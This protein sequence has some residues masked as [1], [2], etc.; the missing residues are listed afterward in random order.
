MMPNGDPR[1][2]FLY[3]TLTVMIDSYIILTNSTDY[4]IGI[5]TMLFWRCVPI[6]KKKT[7]GQL[8]SEQS[9]ASYRAKVLYLLHS[10][11][12]LTVYNFPESNNVSIA[13]IKLRYTAAVG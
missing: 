6:E 5:D 7:F 4:N 8:N 1:D 2:G 13:L 9:Q 12:F 11:T 3:P 10:D